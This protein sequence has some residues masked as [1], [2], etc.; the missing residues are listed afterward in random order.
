MKRFLT[1]S[2]LI[3]IFLIIGVILV[4]YA[5]GKRLDSKGKLVGVGIIQI[6][7]TPNEAKV[8]LNGE[9]KAKSDTNLENLKPGSYTVKLQKDH[10]HT[11]EKLVEVKEGFVT[12]LKVSLFPSNPSLTALTF[13]GVFSPTLSPNRKTVVFGKQNSQDSGIYALQLG[14][15]QFFF[16]NPTEE[17]KIVADTNEFAFSKGS[18]EWSFDSREILVQ[19]QKL[20]STETEYFLLD[21]SKINTNPQNVTSR[22]Q[23]IKEDWQKQKQEKLANLLKKFSQDIVELSAEA[24]EISFSEDNNSVLI[25]KKDN[26]AVLQDLK[27]SPIPNSKRATYNLP[28]ADRYLWFDGDSKHLLSVESNSLN[29]LDSDGTNKFSLF[30][31]DFDPNTIFGWSDASKIVISI[32]LN[33]RFNPLPNLYTIGL[34]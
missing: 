28:S 29:I 24:K 9:Y 33:S 5:Q 17:R 21:V 16:A 7:S 20:G 12:P 10:Y 30:T 3:G 2:L 8:Y 4:I 27:P 1:T 34:R 13:D 6:D 18:F 26:S 19:T 14:N 22:F 32:N 31:G 25:V 23:S 15:G 11:W